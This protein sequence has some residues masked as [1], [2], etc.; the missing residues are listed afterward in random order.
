MLVSG[1]AAAF[2]MLITRGEAKGFFQNLFMFIVFFFVFGII[3]AFGLW[4]LFLFLEL[5]QG[6]VNWWES[7]PDSTGSSSN[8]N[9]VPP[10]FFLLPMALMIGFIIRSNDK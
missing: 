6:A 3:V 1:L 4:F 2:V 10:Y 5:G 9:Q 8:G 7:Q